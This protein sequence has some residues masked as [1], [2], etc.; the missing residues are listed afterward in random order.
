MEITK[1][2]QKPL[3]PYPHTIATEWITELKSHLFF[4]LCINCFPDPRNSCKEAQ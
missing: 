2:Y 1:Q 3:P 4:F